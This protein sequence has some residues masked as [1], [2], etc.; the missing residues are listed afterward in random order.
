MYQS[1]NAP[2]LRL[3]FEEGE[4]SRQMNATNVS[5]TWLPCEVVSFDP[6]NAESVD[7]LLSKFGPEGLYEIARVLMQAADNDISA[8]TAESLI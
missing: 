4:I 3:I 7:R 8:A 6:S 5:K 2:S 1:P